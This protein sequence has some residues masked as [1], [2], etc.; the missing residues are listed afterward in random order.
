M[1]SSCGRAAVVVGAGK[2]VRYRAKGRSHCKRKRQGTR[3][4]KC[5]S[6]IIKTQ[7]SLAIKA[8][9]NPTH[10]F[11]HLY[12][13]ICQ[14]EWIHKALSLVLSN[15]GARTAGI[16]GATRAT[17]DSPEAYIGLIREIQQELPEKRFRPV[18]VRR[19][20]I[21]RFVPLSATR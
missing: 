10:K 4:L 18:P 19:V 12:R 9:H 16:D 11:D 3:G 15:K 14:E 8:E 13:L 2:T 20:Q 17:Y 21:V 1:R 6:D 7:R 5:M